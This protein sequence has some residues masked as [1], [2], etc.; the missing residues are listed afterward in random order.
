MP[1]PEKDH[2]TYEDLMNWEGPERYELIDGEVYLLASPSPV[3]QIVLGEI[4]RQIATYLLGKKCRAFMA[5][6]DVNLFSSKKKW[7][8]Q[9]DTIIQPDLSIICD[10]DKIDPNHGCKGAPDMVLEVV[11]PSSQRYDRLVKLNLY[12]RAGIKEYWLVDPANRIVT[13]YAYEN[14]SYKLIEVAGEGD[15]LKVKV[16]DNCYVDLS[17]VFEA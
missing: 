15:S 5:P 9:A 11:S 14:G 4:Y 6:F 16:L 13:V 12:Q 3:H 7:N 17:R 8:Y 1:L 10:R 2:Y